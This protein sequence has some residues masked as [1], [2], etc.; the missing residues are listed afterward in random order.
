MNLAPKPQT[1]IR[2]KE[3]TH[4]PTR[5]PTVDSTPEPTSEP[6]REPTRE[7]TIEPTL[8]PTPGKFFMN[9]IRHPVIQIAFQNES[10][11]Q[12]KGHQ[13]FNSSPLKNIYI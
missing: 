4:D 1:A 5:E 10:I 8:E 3:P 11:A 12:K 7:P 9:I 6:T 13:I 2:T